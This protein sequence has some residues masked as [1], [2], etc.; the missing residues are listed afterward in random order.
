M[1]RRKAR[2][3]ILQAIFQ[4]DFRD[5]CLEEL[6]PNGADA[7]TK[8]TLK[9]I[10]QHKAEIDRLISRYAQGWRLERIFSVDRNILRLAIYELLYSEL[11]G[12][13]VI[14]EAVELAKKYGTEHSHVFIN[15][16]LDRIWKARRTAQ[17]Q[18]Q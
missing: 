11:P 12:E 8:E 3:L 13:V 17:P 14:N 9:G 2:K 18:R 16:I 10:E 4:R 7:Y 1:T 15:G 6:L 5:V